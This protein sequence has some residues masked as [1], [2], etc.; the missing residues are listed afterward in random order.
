[1]LNS[2]IPAENSLWRVSARNGQ[3]RCGSHHE[4]D[5][6]VYSR[7]YD[8]CAGRTEGITPKIIDCIDEE[9]ERVDRN[10]NA[11]YRSVLKRLQDDAARE[12]LRLLQRAWLKTRWKQCDNIADGDGGQAAQ[13]DDRN[14]RLEE[15]ARRTLWLHH[16]GR[17]GDVQNGT[18]RKKYRPPITGPARE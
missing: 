10:L 7:R 16:Y 3:G 4:I 13:I 18:D 15:T 14:C 17:Q 6:N 5:K 11:S 8:E 12:T 2:L 9:F 1:M